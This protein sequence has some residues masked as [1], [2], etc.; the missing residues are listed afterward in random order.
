MNDDPVAV[1][2]VGAVDEGGTLN[3]A[4]PGVLTNDSDADLD[5]LTVN[6]T[7][8]SGPGERHV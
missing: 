2:D 7:P 3:V 1:D 5:P 6:T 8:V 4:A